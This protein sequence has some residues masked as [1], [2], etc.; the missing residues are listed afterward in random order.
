M[1]APSLAASP[2]TSTEPGDAIFLIGASR[3]VRGRDVGRIACGFGVQLLRVAAE[4]GFDVQ[5]RLLLS[6]LLHDQAKVREVA[7]HRRGS[8]TASTS[9]APS[10]APLACKT[11]I[12]RDHRDLAVAL[13]FGDEVAHVRA[14]DRA[15]EGARGSIFSRGRL[16]LQ[17]VAR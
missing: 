5:G 17:A 7:R 11:L 6:D 12:V 1:N 3:W 16:V 15:P 8:F 4:I 14:E 10:P 9:G 13:G 2:A